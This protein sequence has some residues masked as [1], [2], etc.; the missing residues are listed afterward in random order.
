MIKRRELKD[1]LS[2]PMIVVS[3]PFKETPGKNSS[4]SLHKIIISVVSVFAGAVVG[5]LLNRY[6]KIL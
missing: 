6:L 5:V 1:A 2:D 3:Q 4:N